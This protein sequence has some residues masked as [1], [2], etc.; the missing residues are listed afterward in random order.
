MCTWKCLFFV[1]FFNDSLT[2]FP[3]MYTFH[4]HFR[5]QSIFKKAKKLAFSLNPRKI[6]ERKLKIAVSWMHFFV[7]VSRKCKNTVRSLIHAA[8]LS[9]VVRHV[10]VKLHHLTH[11]FVIQQASFACICDWDWTWTWNHF[12]IFFRLSLQNF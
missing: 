10:D 9:L 1:L 6:I 7:V 12:A 11:S 4:S 5:L 8:I 2:I 3:L